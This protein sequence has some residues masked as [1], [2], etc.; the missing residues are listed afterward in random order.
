MSGVRC[1][2]REGDVFLEADM[3]RSETRNPKPETS[4]RVWLLAA[5][6]KTLWAAVAPVVIGT[7]MAWRDGVL[8]APAALAALTGALLIQIGTNYWND[9]ADFQKGAD[10]AERTGPIRA[11]QAGLVTPA[12]MKRAAILTFALAAM[13]G[14]YLVWR[15]GWPL[16]L[17]VGLSILCGF[18]YTAGPYPIGYLGLGEFFVLIFFGPVAVGGTYYVQAR[19]MHTAVIISGL[20]PGLLACAILVVNNLRDADQDARAGKRTL[21]VRF[22][23]RFAKAEYAFCVGG[24]ALI[25]LALYVLRAHPPLLVLPVLMLLAEWPAAR[26]IYSGQEGR[27]L[28]AALGQTARVLLLYS[29]LFAMAWNLG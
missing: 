18:L 13:V 27:A 17:I 11:T 12:A 26:R 20:A 15:G 19:D 14:A 8:H 6:P 24:A 7:A 10:T 4:F 28:N 3:S 25:P 16:A 1:Q 9:Y 29:I 23:K 2:G 21:A 5:R 22:G